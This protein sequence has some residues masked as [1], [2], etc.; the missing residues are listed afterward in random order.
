M[1]ERV[2]SL[3]QEAADMQIV[4]EHQRDQI[5]V[6]KQEKESIETRMNDND[7]YVVSLRDKIKALVNEKDTLSG[8]NKS[9]EEEKDMYKVN[10][11][12]LS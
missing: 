3:K 12:V 7:Q 9:L 10:Q 5:S 11:I 8:K 2:D 4:H 6:L 1:R